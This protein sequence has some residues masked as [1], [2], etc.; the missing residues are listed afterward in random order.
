MPDELTSPPRKARRY[1][2]R[3][4]GVV[5]GLLVLYL[6]GAYLLIPALWRG[7]V[8][9]HPSLKDIPGITH[10]RNGIPGDP[11]NVALIGTEADLITIMVAAKWYPA[12]ELSFRSSLKI[13]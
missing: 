2:K 11:L 4:A 13:A 3:I 10:T 1:L 9:R 5:A 8:R 7:Y 12:D 6:V